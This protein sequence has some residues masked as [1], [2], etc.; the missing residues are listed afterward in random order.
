MGDW[1][2]RTMTRRLTLAAAAAVALI[3]LGAAPAGARHAAPAE[4]FG[5]DLQL[6][7]TR[8]TKNSADMTYR[9]FAAWASKAS[10]RVTVVD[11]NKT[12][13]DTSDDI[14]YRGVSLKTLVGSFDDK[15]PKTFNNGLAAKGYNVV[16]L[17]MDGFAATYASADIAS[18]GGKVILAYLANGAPL[19]VPAATLNSSG[20]P[21][22][23]PNWPLKVVSSDPSVTGKMK[24]GGV[25][26][27]SIVPAVAAPA[28]APAEPFGWDL[29]LRNTRATKNSADMTYRAFAAW[30]SKA[31]RRVTVV[32]DNKT[33]GDT[34]DDISYRGVSLKTL[35]GSFDD[36]DPKD[37]QQRPG[38]EGLQR[39]DPR[40]GR[41][42]RDVRERRHRESRRQ[43]HPRLPGQRCAAGRA[44]GDPEQQRRAELEAE[45]AA[46]GRQQRSERHRQDE[47]RRRGAREHRAGGGGAGG[48][49]LLTAG[50]R[51]AAA[52]GR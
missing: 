51:R 10:R 47:A 23:K 35:V 50:G 24:P 48:R 29:Q 25:V 33:P 27:V 14:S 8:A 12:P 19:A 46:Q 30:A 9:A 6:R 52:A 17:G 36:K 1:E 44:R 2:E 39:R 16:I 43:G 22:W 26:R 38:G 31:S 40:H 37:V 32:D 45:L 11:D 7:N 18:L 49:P 34:S 20:E 4:P 42:R 3:L 15:D 21:S 5:W 41:L 28:A 13:G